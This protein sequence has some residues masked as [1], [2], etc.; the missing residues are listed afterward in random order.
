MKYY[1][2]ETKQYCENQN[3][4]QTRI[5]YPNGMIEDYFDRTANGETFDIANIELPSSF[6]K[7]VIEKNLLYIELKY[8]LKNK[9]NKGRINEIKEKL[10]PADDEEND[11][12]EQE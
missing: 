1:D 9:G 6:D 5:P 11:E 12:Q 10:Y 3:S 8:L 7:D 2:V 4:K